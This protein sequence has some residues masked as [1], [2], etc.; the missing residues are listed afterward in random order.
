M[1]ITSELHN[2]QKLRDVG[3]TQQQAETLA[4]VIESAQQQGFEKFAAVLE[5]GLVGVRNDLAAGLASVRNEM[6]LLESR[7][8]TRIESSLRDQTFKMIAVFV[9]L[10]S[11]A[12][13]VIK[14]F[15][16]AG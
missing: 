6:A 9:A 4:T 16:G 14:L 3:F 11:V 1:P 2:V 15:P 13:A 8:E 10:L 7:L 5:Q 12:V